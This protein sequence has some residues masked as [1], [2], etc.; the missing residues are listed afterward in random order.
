MSQF[1]DFVE[2]E[3]NELESRDV[4]NLFAM[5]RDNLQ[6]M[7]FEMSD[8]L[9]DELYSEIERQVK[10]EFLNREENHESSK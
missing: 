4:D 3:L 5:L 10:A 6:E 2:S 8:A 1:K 9:D 7:N